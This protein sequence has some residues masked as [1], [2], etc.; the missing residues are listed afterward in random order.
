MLV[1]SDMREGD[2]LG[3]LAE[4]LR[5][6]LGRRASAGVWRLPVAQHEAEVAGDVA[7]LPDEVVP[8]DAGRDAASLAVIREELGDC[9]RCKLHSGRKN[10]VFGVGNPAAD[11]V[12]VGEGPG[13]NEDAR[14][15]Q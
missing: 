3:F 11:L 9:R 2:E 7:D 6:H 4:Q 15:T 1:R 8:R 13:A 12:F 5:R 14:S 10:L